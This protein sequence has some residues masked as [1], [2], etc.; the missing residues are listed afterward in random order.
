MSANGILLNF[1][2]SKSN[3]VINSKKVVKK[4]VEKYFGGLEKIFEKTLE[5]SYLMILSNCNGV[6]FSLRIFDGGLTTLNI[7]YF[8]KID[9]DGKTTI[10]VIIYFME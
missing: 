7:E 5:E 4:I 9:D 10:T 2:Q 3:A 8:N 6:I 1:C